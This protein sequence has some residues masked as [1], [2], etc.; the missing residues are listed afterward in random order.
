[1]VIGEWTTRIVSQRAFLIPQVT[2]T[3]PVINTATDA[4]RIRTVTVT[5]AC[6]DISIVDAVVAAATAEQP[7]KRI[8]NWYV[9]AGAGGRCHGTQQ[10][11]RQKQ[12]SDAES[13]TGYLGETERTEVTTANRANA[14]ERFRREVRPRKLNA[15]RLQENSKLTQVWA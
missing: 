2:I 11:D 7:V 1:M 9:D 12:C 10:S 6:V 5:V 15:Q 4:V 3:E 8:K 14:G 13:H